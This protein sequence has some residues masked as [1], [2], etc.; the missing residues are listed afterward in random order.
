[1]MM[2]DPMADLGGGGG[3][4]P[5]DGS[6]ESSDGATTREVFDGMAF[7]MNMARIERIRSVMGIASGCIVGICGFTGFQGFG[8]HL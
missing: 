6:G 2:A 7:Q 3:H 1:M 8:T 5:Q 4:Q